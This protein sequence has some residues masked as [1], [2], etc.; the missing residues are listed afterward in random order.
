MTEQ[1][2]C[3]GYLRRLQEQWKVWATESD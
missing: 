3:F 1:E 2:V